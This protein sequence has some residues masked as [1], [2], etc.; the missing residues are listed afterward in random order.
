MEDERGLSITQA[1]CPSK[2]TKK[3]KD[4]KQKQIS[5]LRCS[6]IIKKLEL[7]VLYENY[8]NFTVEK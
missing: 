5:N 4:Q 8:F 1:V 7:N 3:L 2:G 6:S